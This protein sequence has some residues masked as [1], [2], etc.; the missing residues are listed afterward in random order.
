MSVEDGDIFGEWFVIESLE[1]GVAKC[2]CSCGT[3]RFVRE[4]YLKNGSSKSCGCISTQLR[5]ETLGLTGVSKLP[6]YGIWTALKRRCFNRNS[7]DFYR[8]GGRGITV[9]DRWNFGEEYKTGFECFLED[10]GPRPSEKHSL[11][12]ID[13]DAGYYPDNCR[14]ATADVQARNQRTNH[15]VEYKGEKMILADAIRLS[16]LPAR[17]VETR[18]RR[19]WSLERAL[20]KPLTDYD[21]ERCIFVEIDGERLNLKDA[22]KKKGIKYLTAYMRIK[23]GWP[24]EDALSL[25]VRKNS[26]NS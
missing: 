13:N 26:L 1:G 25:D 19:G 22:A 4:A 21:E 20:E 3:K 9:C 7:K 6:E 11:D 2:L 12:R 15:W 24:V 10:M 14:W 18:I 5:L 8:Y 17:Q 23:R 16:G